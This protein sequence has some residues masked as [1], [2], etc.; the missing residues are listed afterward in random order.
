[1][2]AGVDVGEQAKLNVVTAD[3]GRGEADAVGGGHEGVVDG[4]DEEL[5]AFH[6]VGVGSGEE[7]VGVGAEGE[8]GG[9]G[10][11]VGLAA[12]T[13][14]V[15][16]EEGDAR[17]DTDGVEE[18]A[19]HGRKGVLGVEVEAVDMAKFG[20]LGVGTGG[21]QAGRGFGHGGSLCCGSWGES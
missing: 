8:R 16:E 3:D 7:L 20:R 11:G 2:A 1:M 17:A 18:V 14:D 5:G 15:G 4:L 21:G 19:A 6:K 10:D 13:G 9:G 12:G